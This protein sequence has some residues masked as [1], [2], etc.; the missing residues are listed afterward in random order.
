MR[1]KA[2]EMGRFT[3]HFLFVFPSPRPGPVQPSILTLDSWVP[4][5]LPL[6][7]SVS[8][9][10]PQHLAHVDTE[11]AQLRQLEDQDPNSSEREPPCPS[12]QQAEQGRCSAQERAA[13]DSHCWHGTV[14][15]PAPAST[16]TALSYPLLCLLLGLR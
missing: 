4:L 16:H 8:F 7:G 2:P 14:P 9:L 1:P 11:Q 13:G 12:Q 3:S 10:C 15:C 5:N 6:P